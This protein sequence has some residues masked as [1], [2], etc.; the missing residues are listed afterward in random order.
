M[1]QL[2][3]ATF[4]LRNHRSHGWAIRQQE[5]W[6]LNSNHL[7]NLQTKYTAKCQLDLHIHNT[8]HLLIQKRFYAILLAMSITSKQQLI[9]LM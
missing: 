5:G 6:Q 1:P 7:K 8:I 4:L 9:L 2:I 3:S